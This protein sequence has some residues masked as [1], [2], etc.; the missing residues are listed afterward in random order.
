MKATDT[1]LELV[2]AAQPA[3]G[4]TLHWLQQHLGQH[5]ELRIGH[6]VG[7]LF[8]FEVIDLRK[9][10]FPE[11]HSNMRFGLTV[12]MN[13]GKIRWNNS[14][15]FPQGNCFVRSPKWKSLW[16]V[17]GIGQSRIHTYKDHRTTI[18]S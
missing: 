17:K 6:W 11:P 12:D 15:E 13:T 8:Y 16:R 5:E 18:F 2:K 4:E 3:L 7:T 1:E 9:D 14:A 10:K